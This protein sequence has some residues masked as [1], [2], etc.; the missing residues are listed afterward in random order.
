MI[1]LS[2]DESP[3][4]QRGSFALFEHGSALVGKTTPACGRGRGS[5]TA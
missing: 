2:R 4:S 1:E 5:G 3:W